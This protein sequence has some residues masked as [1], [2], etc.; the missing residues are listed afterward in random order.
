MLHTLPPAL[1]ST[2]PLFPG[3]DSDLKNSAE[4]ADSLSFATLDDEHSRIPAL[5]DTD[6]LEAFHRFVDLEAAACEHCERSHSYDGSDN[7]LHSQTQ[8]ARHAAHRLREACAA[9][10]LNRRLHA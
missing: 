10:L 6:L 7:G 4:L 8:R 9:E 5:S 3:S 1:R 2:G